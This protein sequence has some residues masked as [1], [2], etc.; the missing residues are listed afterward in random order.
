MITI[1]KSIHVLS[2]PFAFTGSLYSDYT[3]FYKR[4]ATDFN[5][6]MYSID[7]NLDAIETLLTLLDY[8]VDLTT[9]VDFDANQAMLDIYFVLR[10]DVLKGLNILPRDYA[11]LLKGVKAINDHTK[12]Y[13][14]D[15]L[16]D[17]VNTEVWYSDCVPYRWAYLSELT[18]EDVSGWNIC[19]IS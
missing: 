1:N 4:L 7:N 12:R 6:M 5:N 18:G 3:L 11:Q 10:N 15:D 17:Y 9:N 2:P 14:T 19:D 16:T 8:M 13:I